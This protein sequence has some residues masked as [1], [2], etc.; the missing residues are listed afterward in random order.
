[1][2]EPPADRFRR[3]DALFDAA[4]DLPGAEQDAF[5]ERLCAGDP[6]LGREVRRLMAAYRSSSGFLDAPAVELAAPLLQE[7]RTAHPAS[8]RLRAPRLVGPFRVIRE[9][10]GTGAARLAGD[11]RLSE[12]DVGVSERDVYLAERDD[13]SGERVTLTLIRGGDGEAFV[14]RFVEQRRVLAGLE[15]PDIARVKDGG[16][17]PDGTPW[18]AAEYVEGEPLDRYCDARALPLA[19]R[20][21]LFD[22][23]CDVVAYAHRRLLVHGGLEPSRILVTA[24]ARLKLLDLG[25]ADLLGLLDA[26]HA[27]PRAPT[28]GSPPL[29]PRGPEYA[30]PEQLRGESATPATDVYALGV[31]LHVLLT[32]RRRSDERGPAPADLE[33]VVLQ[34]MRSEP[35]RRYPTVAALREDVRRHLARRGRGMRNES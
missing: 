12:R 11:V 1:M 16:V 33:A 35:S 23:L 24:G 27:E 20:L 26:L 4:L 2:P 14:A 9:I 15:H 30:A 28:T 5:I 25:V 34:A 21:E 19:R 3:A 7:E 17:L 13:G 6:E 32:G 31:L 8:A 10:G 18:W 22:A 29:P